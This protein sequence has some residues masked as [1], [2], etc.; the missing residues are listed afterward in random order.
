MLKG[1]VFSL[2][3]GT[4]DS[5][6]STTT[7]GAEFLRL[8]KARLR[9]NDNQMSVFLGM[10]HEL[11][12]VFDENENIPT[13]GRGLAGKARYYARKFEI[14]KVNDGYTHDDFPKLHNSTTAV[15]RGITRRALRGARRSL[16]TRCR[17]IRSKSSVRILKGDVADFGI[18]NCIF[19]LGPGNVHT[20]EHRCMLRR[21]N[22][23]HPKLLSASLLQ[24][25]DKKLY[26][27][28]R[29]RGL[30]NL[31]PSKNYF[32]LK[33]FVDGVQ[34]S[35]NG[36]IP[37]AIPI[38]ATIDTI[39]PYDEENMTIDWQNAVRVP[40]RQTKPFFIAVYHGSKKPNLFQF[41]Q[42]FFDELLFL[43]PSRKPTDGTNRNCVVR[44]RTMI[45]DS[46]MV[47]MLT[48]EFFFIEA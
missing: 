27:M 39:A 29:T 37:Q 42:K 45:C 10:Y 12:P 6:F 3:G 20:W 43:D 15:A 32:E 47:S 1:A 4:G 26:Q 40:D 21:L 24:V 34:I 30:L 13:T 41:F 38:A 23:A 44:L 14:R 25:A 11:R 7:S 5:S 22:A 9:M 17:D 16:P 8:M 46:P 33:V 18:E 28:E 48:G 36:R 19:L 31:R 2:L 35:K